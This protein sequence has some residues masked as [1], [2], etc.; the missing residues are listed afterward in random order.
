MFGFSDCSC[1]YLLLFYFFLIYSLGALMVL[2]LG[3]GKSLRYNVHYLLS[4]FLRK[5]RNKRK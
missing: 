2:L 3:F 4:T 5:L 1:L